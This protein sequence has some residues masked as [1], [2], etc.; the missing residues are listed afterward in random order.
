MK[1]RTES[2][3]ENLRGLM[4]I[5][6]TN[7]K[8][9]IMID[10]RGNKHSAFEITDLAGTCHVYIPDCGWYASIAQNSRR[11]IRK[12]RNTSYERYLR[13][14]MWVNTGTGIKT[15]KY[16]MHDVIAVMYYRDKINK[17]I[18]K[19]E[20]VVINHMDLDVTNNNPTN[21]EVVTN[22]QNVIHGMFVRA[23][24]YHYGDKYFKTYAD[25]SISP[26]LRIPLSAEAVETAH[27][28]LYHPNMTQTEDGRRYS[29]ETVNQMI[30][31]LG[32]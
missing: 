7:S 5:I 15:A 4:N 13:S 11:F 12:C 27:D 32:L 2:M 29:L 1:N 6:D 23:L 9:G 22:R 17:F 8:E 19:N 14:D 18:E 16:Y 24:Q 26:A 21:I 28:C 31:L 25:G 30:E 3:A 20:R 10:S